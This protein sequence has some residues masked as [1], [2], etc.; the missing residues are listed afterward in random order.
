MSRPWSP[1]SNPQTLVSSID[2]LHS[3]LMISYFITYIILIEPVRGPFCYPLGLI[4][5]TALS[6]I[7]LNKVII[8]RPSH[9]SS[10]H[11]V[12]FS[13]LCENK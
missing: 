3:D 1:T 12:T 13:T 11:S 2:R 7:Q 5:V 6:I 8:Y 10:Q 4:I 9:P